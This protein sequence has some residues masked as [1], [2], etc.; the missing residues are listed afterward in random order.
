MHIVGA[1]KERKKVGKERKKGKERGQ[2]ERPKGGKKRAEEIDTLESAK[3][4]H[5][6]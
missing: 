1:D 2:R 5:C 4:H 3:D 6:D